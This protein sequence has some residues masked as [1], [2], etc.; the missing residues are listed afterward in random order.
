MKIRILMVCLGNICRSP[1]AK[2]IMAQKT[3]H[4]NIEVDSAGTANYHENQAADS[5]SIAVAK[6][7]GLDLSDHR[8]RAFRKEDFK[9]FSHIFAMDQ[10][11]YD[12]LVKQAQSEEERKKIQFM[13]PTEEEV[14]D[15]YYHDEAAFLNVFR[16]LE[17]ACSAQLKKFE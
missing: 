17:Q 12:F 16:I 15:P 3:A 14:P 8:A 6:S 7:F 5:R 10:Q 9:T 4:L 1:L 2:V 13:R 11:N